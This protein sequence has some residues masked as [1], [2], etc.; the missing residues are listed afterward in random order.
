MT[1]RVWRGLDQL[2][3]GS[4]RDR[5]SVEELAEH[6]EMAVAEKVRAGKDEAAAR[7]EVRLE[8]GHPLEARERLFEG[9][10]GSLLE[11]CAQDG[12]YAL[13][14]L[15]K[16]K[17]FSA[18]CMLTIALGVGASTALFAVVDAVLLRPLPFPEPSALVRVYDTNPRAGV[19][20]TGI[21]TGNLADW[22]R[23]ARLFRGIAGYYSMGRTLSGEGE[24]EVVL[25][26][27]VSEDFFTVLGQGALLGR[28]F[29]PEEFAR[30]QFN[31]A[32][33]PTGPDPVVV[34][35]HG[36]WQRRF[37][38]D[39]GIVGR[40]LTVERRPF[41]VVGVMPAGFDMPEA[42]VQMWIAWDV[43]GDQ[44][45]DQHYLGGLARLQASA[46]PAQ[47]ASD[48]NAVAET[49]ARE[50]PTT[51]EG[52]GA[53]L[54]PLKEAMVGDSGRTLWVLLAA[55]GLLLVV[56]CANVAVL[57]LARGL[58]RAQEA[59]LRLA[60]GATRGRLLRQ[61]LMES[62]LVA[63]GGGLL[64]T[65]LALASVGFLRAT[66]A[67]LPRVHEVV[68]DP[69]ALLFALAATTAAALVAGLPYAWRRARVEPLA[70]LV[71][72]TSRS[73]EGRGR[74]RVRDGLVVAEVAL[75]VVLLAGASLLLRSYER[76][77][78]QDPGF[79]PRGVLVAPVFLDM[80]GY[81]S[82]EKSRAYYSSL[83]ERLQALPGV[84]SAGGATALPTSP[85]GPDFERPVWPE[86]V[87]NEERSRRQAWVRM[88]TPRYFE[89][90]GMPMVAGRAFDDA[91]GPQKPR[92]VILSEGLARQLWPRGDATGRRLVVD[93]SNAGTY[94]YEVVGVVG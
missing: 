88:I 91:D 81:G 58:E 28:T 68:L 38:G 59:S 13:R 8:L 41:R 61:F 24:S 17:V 57:S 2:L 21:T 60:L 75:A 65:L 30:G 9:R 56:A 52:W 51:N 20:Q 86:E 64:G 79:D 34:L 62:L 93:Y 80:E 43:S 89:T 45:R 6:V 14:L 72:G 39:P 18:L 94:P 85:L 1:K 92:E 40:S 55:V 84:L 66:E 90:L 78:A 49:L 47:A 63:G 12:L 31:S 25:T 19:E 83:L 27:Q 46:T 54:V 87:L 67:S 22:R 73:T 32:A 16:R 5:E 74:H 37:G 36:L 44:P 15:R 42:G 4:R 82:G 71:G 10:T 3:H 11:A 7:R 48:L 23:R 29:N 77:R 50:H 70:D 53:R 35:G 76:L 33:A 26:A 69:R